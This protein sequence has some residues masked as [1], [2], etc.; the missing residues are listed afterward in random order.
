MQL[1]C[2]LLR[3]HF[4]LGPPASLNSQTNA[5]AAAT[6]KAEAASVHTAKEL[7]QQLQDMADMSDAAL[8]LKDSHQLRLLTS[9]QW[10]LLGHVQRMY[11]GLYQQGVP[12]NAGSCRQVQF[13]VN[14]VS[15][16]PC[17]Q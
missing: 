1:H 3:L 4:M 5:A 11:E 12:G 14:S 16:V 9:V 10:Q 15:C 17:L 8:P 7:L 13:V 2:L 6:A